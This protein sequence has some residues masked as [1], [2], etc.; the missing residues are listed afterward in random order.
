SFAPAVPLV[1][2]LRVAPE[3]AV[4][5]GAVSPSGSG[6]P[7][8]LASVIAMAS[9]AVTP[10]TAAMRH[11]VISISCIARDRQSPG[12]RCP[13]APPGANR[14]GR[15]ALSRKARANCQPV[16]TAPVAATACKRLL[17]AILRD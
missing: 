17:A 12:C 13:A 9:R 16:A 15:H 3:L 1:A 10:A 14:A 7:L 6:L 5:A 8:Q 11:V 4:A 2:A